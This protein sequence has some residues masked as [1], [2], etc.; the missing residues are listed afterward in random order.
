MKLL[1]YSA[2]PFV[3]LL[4]PLVV[5]RILSLFLDISLVLYSLAFVACFIT[6]IFLLQ[7]SIKSYSKRWIV[8]IVISLI[9]CT[10]GVVNSPN[11]SFNRDLLNNKHAYRSVVKEVI[12]DAD[13][14][15][16][17]LLLCAPIDTLKQLYF[18]ALL[19]VKSDSDEVSLLPGDIITF[20]SILSD[21][22]YTR[23][24]FAFE[25]ATY[26][27]NKDVEG[28]FFVRDKNILCVGKEYTIGRFFYLV[29]QK[30]EK[31]LNRLNVS[32]AEFGIISA[33]VLGNKSMLEYQTK[34]NFS[35]AGAIHILSVS[36]L[37]V[38]IIYLMLMS[39]FGKIGKGF[40]SLLKVVVIIGVL[41]F[42]AAIAGMAPS[43]FRATIMFSVFVISKW[44]SHRYN[45]YHSLAIAAFVILIINPYSITHAGFWLSFFAVMSIVYFYPK[46][47]GWFYFTTPWTKYV[48][49]LISVS[50]A[51]Q[52]GTFPL[53][54]YL[55][56]FFPTW[57][58]VSNFL[59]IPILPF[60]LIGALLVV[61]L[62]FNFILIQL[63][64]GPLRIMFQYLNE[65]TQWVGDLS[66][67]KFTGLQLSFYHLIGFYGAMLLFVVW[68][69]LKRGKYLVFS[70]FITLIGFVSLLL[71]SYTK[72]HQQVFTVHQVKGKTA[73][74]LTEAN[75]CTCWVGQLLD[76]KEL[77]YTVMPL[78]LHQEAASVIQQSIDSV[79][80][81]PVV[82]RNNNVLILN[83]EFNIDQ[84]GKKLDVVVF[85]A[86]LKTYKIKRL[87]NKIDGQLLVFDSSFSRSQCKYLR[88]E[89]LKRKLKAHFVML[90]GAYVVVL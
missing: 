80:I 78:V 26:M 71:S 36:G 37:H 7:L 46:I 34:V 77:N 49:A 28:Q 30:A 9:V 73:V 6:V 52:I 5:G 68:R 83:E 23:N 29:R 19:Y 69:N 45:I 88:R 72:Y 40:V 1:N 14:K 65:L 60:M 38:G 4:I 81:C 89:I 59:I 16:S 44:R 75:K 79:K 76:D 48:W 41:W 61:I 21:F 43:V 55:F 57:F 62:P 82:T 51:A 10:L 67:A 32:T 12:K 90:D 8:G 54:I 20:E 27:K 56:G 3:R 85:T 18:N 63:I 13:S 64:A 53:G 87:L 35:S 22:E 50:V 24:P 70:L 66:Y 31:K 15:Q 58:L 47:N 39:V 42:Y 74:T 86:K 33:L 84:I 25:Y 17:V 11:Y 2:V